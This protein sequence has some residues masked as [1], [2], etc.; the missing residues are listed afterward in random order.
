MNDR[1]IVVA[2]S[3]LSSNTGK[4]TR[5]CELITRL[6]SW[7]AIK[8]TRGHHRSCGKDPTGCCV[9]DLLRDKP[10]IRLG[11]AANYESGKDC[12]RSSQRS[13]ARLGRWKC[14]WLRFR[15]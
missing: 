11:R 2:V 1:P 10:S 7:E 6:P 13:A 15:R 3:G 12:Q 8:I 4:T 14:Y 9:S 5:M